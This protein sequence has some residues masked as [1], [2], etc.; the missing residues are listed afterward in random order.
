MNE[1]GLVTNIKKAIQREYPDS[2]VMKVHGSPYQMIGVPDLLVIIRGVVIAMEVKLPAARESAEHARGRASLHQIEQIRQINEA[3]GHAA[4]VLSVEEALDFIEQVVGGVFRL[5]PPVWI[6]EP[7]PKNETIE[8]VVVFDASE[9]DDEET[10]WWAGQKGEG[11]VHWM[12][13]ASSLCG[14]LD[15]EDAVA[16]TAEVSC[17]RCLKIAAAS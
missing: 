11:A 8:Q 6:E 9:V 16:V 1:R 4:V 10:G 5:D 3:G 17:K 12:D 15:N 2:W 7:D 14:T 13:T